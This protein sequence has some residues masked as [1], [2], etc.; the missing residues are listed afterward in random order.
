MG[1]SLGA[2]CVGC[3][4]YLWFWLCR[5]RHEFSMDGFGYADDGTGKLPQLGHFLV[6]PWVAMILSGL[7]VVAFTII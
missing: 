7:S 1:I 3:C 4:C 6:K 5:W 2:Y